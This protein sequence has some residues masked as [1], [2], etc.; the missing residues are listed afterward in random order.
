M[1]D[2]RVRIF[3]TGHV[4]GVFFRQT[5]KVMAIKNDIQGWVRNLKDGRVEAVLQGDERCLDRVIEWAHAGPANAMVCDVEIRNEE[6]RHGE[7]ETFIVR[8]P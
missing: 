8:Y 5:L 3:V 1:T 4:Q 2:R 6:P 7:F